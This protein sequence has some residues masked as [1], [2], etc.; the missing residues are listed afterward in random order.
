[1]KKDSIYILNKNLDLKED[2]LMVKK[3]NLLKISNLFDE[4]DK[5]L[6]T[7]VNIKLKNLNGH[8]QMEE[9]EFQNLLAAKTLLAIEPAKYK[10]NDK[11]IHAVYGKGTITFVKYHKYIR[12]WLYTVAFSSNTVVVNEAEI[13]LD[14]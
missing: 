12:K 1:M 6:P 10:E 14:T 7:I 8:Y 11:V 9:N 2:N 4:T 3:G 13:K 5:E